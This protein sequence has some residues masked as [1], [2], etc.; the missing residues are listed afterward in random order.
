MQAYQRGAFDQAL[1]A[2]KQAA[3]LYERQGQIRDQSR[4]LV[5]AAQASEATGQVNQ[6]LQQLEVAFGLAQKLQDRAWTVTVLDSLGRSYLAAKQ[7]DAATQ[8]LT[9]ALEKTNSQDS[10][11]TLAAIQNNL[12]L[13]QVAQQQ[14]TEALT[15][16]TAAVDNASAAGE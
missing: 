6:A 10:P 9:Q 8:Y 12:G 5:N 3:Q 4:A 14:M 2:W 11:R 16:F 7:P 13:A 15:S 1:T